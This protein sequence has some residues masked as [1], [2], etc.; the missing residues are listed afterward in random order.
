METKKNTGPGAQNLQRTF[1]IGDEWLYYKFYAGAKTADLLLTEMIK[2]ATEQLLAGGFIDRWFFIRYAD[3]DLHTRVRFHIPQPPYIFNVIQ[4]MATLARP[5]IE[6]DLIWKVQVD[7]YQREI[8]RYGEETMDAAEVL[9]FHDSQMIVEMLD[10]ITGDEGEKYRWLFGAR[11]IDTLL[12]DFGYSLEEKMD[13][14]AIL[15]ENFGREFGIDKNLRDQLKNKFRTEKPS[16]EIV[17][18]RSQDE[19]NEM[20]PLYDLLAKRS[21]AVQPIAAEI[22]G[23]L[24]KKKRQVNELMGSY[25]HMTMNRLFRSRQRVHE[26]VMYDF[27]YNYYRSEV[28]KKKYGQKSKKKK[29]DKN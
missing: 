10:M 17:L 1:I 28:A 4:A 21:Q 16:L 26:L 12:D 29:K 22:R 18:D 25:I 9:F 19:G 27:L 5:Y 13:L 15:K 20:V 11:D 6:Q 2:P 7:S 14:L 23:V 24:E 3:P 8:E